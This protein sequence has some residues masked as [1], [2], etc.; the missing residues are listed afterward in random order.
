MQYLKKSNARKLFSTNSC[1]TFFCLLHVPLVFA[2]AAPKALSPISM[3]TRV[4]KV[5]RIMSGNL[6]VSGKINK[7]KR[8][9]KKLKMSFPHVAR[10]VYFSCHC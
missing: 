2:P 1:K 8:T 6:V 10:L 7:Y 4:K 3:L 5:Y 9:L